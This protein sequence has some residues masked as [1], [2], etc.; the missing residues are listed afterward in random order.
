MDDAGEGGTVDTWWDGLSGES[1]DSGIDK[2]TWVQ[3][4][5]WQPSAA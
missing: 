2:L 3:T 1:L 4:L 5:L